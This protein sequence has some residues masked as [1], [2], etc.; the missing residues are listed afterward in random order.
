[1]GQDVVGADDG[2]AAPVQQAGQVPVQALGQT[3]GVARQVPAGIQLVLPQGPEEGGVPGLIDVGPQR[4]AQVPDP[5]VPQ[6]L[7]SRET[8]M[9][10]PSSLSMPVWVTARLPLTWLS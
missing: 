9:D 4:T 5:P 8:A 10:I 6:R 1:M 7:E 2:G 3:Q